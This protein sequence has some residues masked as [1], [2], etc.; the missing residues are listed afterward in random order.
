MS[1]LAQHR[2]R[3]PDAAPLR[4]TTASAAVAGRTRLVGEVN[5]PLLD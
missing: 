2:E 3:A 4:S 1:Q 5:L